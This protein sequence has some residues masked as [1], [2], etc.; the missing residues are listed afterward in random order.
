MDV[1][2]WA[3]TDIKRLRTWN[4][5]WTALIIKPARLTQ[6]REPERTSKMVKPTKHHEEIDDGI[7]GEELDA[8]KGGEWIQIFETPYKLLHT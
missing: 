7:T 5:S 8:I 3:N 1:T 4:R 6:V 2:K